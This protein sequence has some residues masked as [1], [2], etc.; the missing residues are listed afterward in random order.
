MWKHERVIVV[1]R[2]VSVPLASPNQIAKWFSNKFQAYLVSHWSDKPIVLPPNHAIDWFQ[3]AVLG[4]SNKRN[5]VTI[6]PHWSTVFIFVARTDPQMTYFNIN[7]ITNFT[8]TSS[9]LEYDCGKLGNIRTFLNDGFQSL[10]CKCY[11]TSV[12]KLN[13]SYI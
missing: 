8:I 11:M 1:K 10:R 2:V 13:I 4:F 5:K 12:P 7:K 6:V 9:N 3:D